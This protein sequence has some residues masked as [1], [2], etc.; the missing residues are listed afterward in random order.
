MTS[1]AKESPY[2]LIV[3]D[4]N[5]QL[6]TL[7]D[8]LKEENL[9]PIC[10]KNGKEALIAINNYDIQVAILDLRLTD[11]DGISLLK[12]LKKI[13]PDLKGIINTA[14]ATLDS[15]VMAVNQEAFAFV[16]KMG[17][18]RDLLSHPRRPRRCAPPA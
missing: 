17:D 2:I 1:N 7:S 14:Y 10:C 8:I 12:K 18:V 13:N 9:Q 6:I 15:A 16:K 5:S 11:D 4:D 3:D